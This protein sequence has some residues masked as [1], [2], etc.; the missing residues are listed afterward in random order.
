MKPAQDIF[1]L[2]GRL[3]PGS[4][5]FAL[6][7]TLLIIAV[8]TIMVI[9]FMQSMRVDR[10]SARSYLEKYR[11]ELAAKSAVKMAIAQISTAIS[12]SSGNADYSYTTELILDP[13]NSG[14]YSPITSISRYYTNASGLVRVTIPLI[15]TTNAGLTYTN[16]SFNVVDPSNSVV[17]NYRTNLFAERKTSVTLDL[18]PSGAIQSTNTFES[19]ADP[20]NYFRATYLPVTNSA[21]K[22]GER[23]AYIVV[24]EQAKLNSLY[25]R[26]VDRDNYATNAE[27]VPLTTGGNTL[28]TPTEQNDFKTNGIATSNYSSVLRFFSSA[29]RARDRRQFYT[30]YEATNQDVIPGGYPD[31]GKPKFNLQDLATN[32]V[33]GTNATLRSEYITGIIERNLPD[34]K[35]RD[36]SFVE[37]GYATNAIKY[38]RRIAANIVDYVD[39]DS[40]PTV[41][42]DGEPVGKE[43][44]P[45]VVAVGENFKWI[46]K[47]TSTNSFTCTFKTQYYVEIWNPYTFPV[48]GDV[49]FQVQGRMS[50]RVGNAIERNLRNY[51]QSFNGVTVQPNEFKVVELPEADEDTY[52]SIVD[53]DSPASGRPVWDSTSSSDI[54][55]P[56]HPYFKFYWNS[57]LVDMTRQSSTFVEDPSTSGMSM[58]GPSTST[59]NSNRPIVGQN[60]WSL[61]FPQNPDSS[62]GKRRVLDPR[63]NGLSN[64]DWTEVVNTSYTNNASWG[65]RFYKTP[66]NANTM[67]LVSSMKARDYVRANP[68]LGQSPTSI[69]QTPLQ[70][71]ATNAT[72]YSLSTDGANAPYYM[73]TNSIRSLGELGNIFDPAQ[74]SDAGNS[75]PKSGPAGAFAAGGGRSLRI[76]QPEFSSSNTNYTWDVRGKRA[77]ELLDL[78]SVNPVSASTGYPEFKGRININTAPPEVLQALFYNIKIK[79]DEYYGTNTA[80]ISTMDESKSKILADAIV[81][82]RKNNGHYTKLSDFY[83]IFS[84]TNASGIPV[85]NRAA[86]YTPN[87]GNGAS[88][89]P[90]EVM[91]RAREEM[92]AKMVNL[93]DTQSRVFR[94]YAVGQAL[95][96]TGKVMSRSNLECLVV[97]QSVRNSSGVNMLVPQIVYEKFY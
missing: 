11:A 57:N 58:T 70:A 69:T 29:D 94:V 60:R 6:I 53:P 75:A 65:G 43:L 50:L 37:G 79:S 5:A 7:S 87:L 27:E 92:F 22:V 59:G 84:L 82:D 35:K 73:S 85:W 68:N 32:N 77:M 28:L 55:K 46:S 64:Y 95:G 66:T 96:P 51:S 9:A 56:P 76:G 39:I 42:S 93:V 83:R 3:A 20:T 67:D 12:D 15:S 23:L 2:E 34:F 4:K 16:A 90:P 13:A 17:L 41:T 74:A 71:A 62:D 81:A 54:T 47:G 18:N 45:M 97:I 91:D 8:L 19:G 63:I 33:Y 25:H 88:D 52:V 31:S 72:P 21:G 49:K 14:T 30:Y 86:A 48:T 26:G 44:F 40:V 38:V 36:P 78:F 10:L 61:H 89:S 80:I 24:D 1:K